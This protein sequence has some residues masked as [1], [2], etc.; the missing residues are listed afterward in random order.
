MAK[1]LNVI[2]TKNHISSHYMRAMQGEQVT[3]ESDSGREHTL[4]N[5]TTTTSEHIEPPKEEDTDESMENI[6][7]NVP[8][9]TQKEPTRR[10]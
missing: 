6:K 1:E 7:D 9:K 10:K 2:A 3:V 8:T 5:P 4:T